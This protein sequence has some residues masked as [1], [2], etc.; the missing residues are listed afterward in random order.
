MLVNKCY[1]KDIKEYEESH[2]VNILT[3]FEKITFSN[4][5]QILSVFYKNV[6]EDELYN[7]VDNYLMEGHSLEELIV[8][9][10]NNLLGY[11]VERAEQRIDEDETNA[12]AGSYDDI[13]SYRYLSDFY[14]HLC[15]QM[16]S[17][18]MSYSEFWSLTTKEMYQA[19]DAIK[20]KMVLDYNRQMQGY[21]T[22]AGLIGGG[23][24]GKL[25]K[26]AP[27]IDLEDLRD[28]DEIIQTEF[29][30]MTREDYKSALALNNMCSKNDAIYNGGKVNGWFHNRS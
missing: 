7:I 18:G 15:M 17:L 11:D 2:D 19:F 8:E 3:L 6:P 24:W 12:I 21:H 16:L 26:E 9:I 25:P 10:R 20:Q 27:Q 5:I 1:L 22:L 23:V 29:G 28:P 4:L 13:R 30:E 14:M